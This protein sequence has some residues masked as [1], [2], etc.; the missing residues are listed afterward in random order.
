MKRFLA[1]L[2]TLTCALAASS[3]ALADPAKAPSATPA[4]TAKPAV[5][6]ICKQDRVPFDVHAGGAPKPEPVAV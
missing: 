3:G 4:S 1:C 2:A 5:K 6:A